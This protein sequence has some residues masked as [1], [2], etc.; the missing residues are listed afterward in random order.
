MC[1]RSIA[2]CLGPTLE[3]ISRILTILHARGALEFDLTAPTTSRF[4]INELEGAIVRRVGD[5][6]AFRPATVLKHII[7]QLA[8]RTY[9][10]AD[11]PFRQPSCNRGVLGVLRP[12]LPGEPF[13]IRST[14][15]HTGQGK[16]P[17]AIACAGAA[18]RS[19]PERAFDLVED[20]WFDHDAAVGVRESCGRHREFNQRP[21][22]S[23]PRERD[24][25]K[26]RQ[27]AGHGLPQE[28]V[29]RLEARGHPLW[30]SLVQ[31][32]PVCS[33]RLNRIGRRFF[34]PLAATDEPSNQGCSV[35]EIISKHHSISYVFNPRTSPLA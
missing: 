23:R 10:A 20:E 12:L 16:H 15:V 31:V 9:Q 33:C 22:P 19:I 14:K 30:R 24:H 27:S 32:S 3:T 8:E 28:I 25:S 29:G 5:N 26:L 2:D 18:D 34:C 1:R 7:L 4:A 13:R 11:E 6:A 35:A 21:N 17:G